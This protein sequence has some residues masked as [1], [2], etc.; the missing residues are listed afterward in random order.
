M[1]KGGFMAKGMKTDLELTGQIRKLTNESGGDLFGVASPELLAAAPPGFRPQDILPDCRAVIVV[2]KRLSDA[3][4][5]TTPSRMFDTMYFATNGFLDQLILKVTDGL[6]RKN[7][8]AV[9]IGPHSLDGQQSMGD[10]S[11]K[12]AAVAAGLGRFGLHSLVLTPQFGPRQRWGAV[13]TDAP[14]QLDMPLKKELCNPDQCERACI[15]SCPA[16]V[17]SEGRREGILDANFL[18][19]G[20]WHYWNIDKS[21]CRTYRA[22]RKN[23]LGWVTEGGHACAICLKVCPVGQKK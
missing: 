17:F 21:A 20:L 9:A 19:G 7:Y 2:G 5:E 8:K 16:R 10:I 23:E 14:L 13:I 15:K 12:H 6:V 3:T 4:V 1:G 22:T 18:P 11:Q